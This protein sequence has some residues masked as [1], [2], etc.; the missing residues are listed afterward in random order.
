MKALSRGN[1]EPERAS[2]PFDRARDGFVIGEGAGIAIVE[3]LEHAK[4]RG[5]KIY[6]ELT[7]YGLSADA[8]HMTAPPEDGGGAARAMQQALDH[9][10]ILP[11]RG[12]YRHRHGTST[13][14][15]ELH[16]TKAIKK[17]FGEQTKVS[18]SA[19]KSMTA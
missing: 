11:G 13:G 8:Y 9:A 2:R 16:Q 6:C 1:D 7:G 14:H 17:V 5:A 3:E 4:K 15:G 18:I 19:T 12:D 10:K